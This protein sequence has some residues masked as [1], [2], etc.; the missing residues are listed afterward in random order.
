MDTV[1]QQP[2]GQLSLHEGGKWMEGN[3]GINLERY[4][5]QGDLASTLALY[6]QGMVPFPL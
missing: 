2:R 3:R 4:W 5:E 1:A 6:S